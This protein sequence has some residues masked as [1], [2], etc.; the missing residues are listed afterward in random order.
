M[1]QSGWHTTGKLEVPANISIVALPAKC[2]ELNP[3]ERVWPFMRDNWLSNP[4]FASHDNIMDRCCEAWNKLIGQPRHIQTIGRRKWA[5]S[6][7][8]VIIVARAIPVFDV[9]L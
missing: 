3:V 9:R 4:V 1:D 5:R 2:P 7:Q 6:M 8:A